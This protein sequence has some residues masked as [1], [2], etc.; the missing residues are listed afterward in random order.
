MTLEPNSVGVGNLPRRIIAVC[1]SKRLTSFSV[2]GTVAF[3]ADQL[4]V[5]PHTLEK[6]AGRSQGP[7]LEW[8]FGSGGQVM[9]KYRDVYIDMGPSLG[10]D[11]PHAWQAHSAE[12]LLG[13]SRQR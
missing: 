3:A 6:T 7:L 9:R 4:K 12:E 1:G 13:E 10:P 11:L 5:S 2:A 8:V